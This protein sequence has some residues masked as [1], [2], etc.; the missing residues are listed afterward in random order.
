MIKLPPA[1]SRV[2]KLIGW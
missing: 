1:V 2:D